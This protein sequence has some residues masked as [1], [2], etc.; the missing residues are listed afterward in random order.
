MKIKL[1]LFTFFFLSFLNNSF[2]QSIST[3]PI[4]DANPS[5]Y[6]PFVNNQVFDTNITVTGIKR[7]SGIAATSALNRFA[8]SRWNSGIQDSN[9]YFEFTLTPNSGFQINFLNFVY[10]AQL[11]STGPVN[12]VF[13]S[14]L[15]N[16]TADIATPVITKS[17][18]GEVTP[19]P[20]DLSTFQSITTPITFRLYGW[21]ASSATGTFSINEFTFNGSVSCAA[22]ST[23]VSATKSA[24]TCSGATA[25]WVAAAGA[26]GYLLDVSTVDTFAT[27]VTDYNGLDVG[28]TTSYKVTGLTEGTTYYYRVRAKNSCYT[29]DN[30]SIQSFITLAVTA[31]NW[32]GT[33]WSNGN[34]S[35]AKNIVFNGNYNSSSDLNACSCQVLSGNIVISSANTLTI[36]N[37]VDVTGGSLTFENSASLIQ[38]GN[39]ANS[40]NITVKKN[41]SPII[42]DDFTYWSSPTQGTQTLLNFS[43]NTQSDKYFDYNND[44]EIVN[45]S[46]TVFSPGIGYVIR[47]P[48]DISSSVAA[49]VPFQF[50]GVPN[51]GTINIPVTVRDSGPDINTGERLIGNP[52]PSAIDA[53]A[54]I[55]ANITSGTGTKTIS[56]TL[57]FWTH[58][59]TLSG[60]NYLST[61]YATYNL[62]G[63]VSV[64][65]G[66]GN[67]T[68]PSKYIASGQGF[69]V[70][71][72][73]PGNVTFNN[74]LR[75]GANNANFYKMVS[76]KSSAEEPSKIWL[77]LTN[78]TTNF[79]QTLIGY[80]PNAT[81]NF[82]QGY[83]SS[84]YDESQPFSLYSVLHNYKLSIQGRSLP[85]ADT[86]IVPL[87]Y[88]INVAGNATITVDHV[89]GVFLGGQNIYLQDNLLQIVHDVKTTPYN[90]TSE[91]GT[92]NDR[93]VLLYIDESL[94]VHDFEL[95]NSNVVIS[96][97]GNELKIKSELENIKQITVFDLLG[98]KVFEK[99]AINNTE[100]RMP[101]I[102]LNN[103]MGIVK[104]TL[105]N[106]QEISK[107]IIF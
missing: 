55:K 57:Y 7:G 21:G 68:V 5:S 75:I 78:Q 103:Q 9:D 31:T 98:R 87:G 16:Y 32:N 42:L 58:N 86:D 11:S 35:D 95:N 13:R 84:V 105:A 28:N 61:D 100:V 4:T 88:S 56:G 101:N 72:D 74:T 82:D 15:D 37:N 33:A 43:P 70:E 63:G 96:K 102:A 67:I 20:I 40:G 47:S 6:N 10:K 48:E 34:P 80:I 79:S 107:K 3:N 36:A 49:S 23:P 59:H 18:P 99:N 66:T 22:L 50:T 94:D 38:L 45:A 53:E 2:A 17:P 54:F 89:E 24:V 41:T 81:D 60:N 104:V 83:D 62:S 19:T 69:F 106:G 12:F 1:H 52:Y 46:T 77:N 39:F 64:G 25:N 85:F 90:F 30:S 76:Q 51:N 97:K 29:S 73:A 92:F 65:S 44:Y 71:V 26:S 8:A 14:S 91:A 93:F 27:F